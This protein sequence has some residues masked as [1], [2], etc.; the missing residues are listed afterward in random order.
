VEESHG[1][2]LHYRNRVEE[3][4]VDMVTLYPTGTGWKRVMVTFYTTGTGWK[5]VMLTWLPST[6]QGQGGRESC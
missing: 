5:R 4:H 6:L 2:L 3:S 1:Y